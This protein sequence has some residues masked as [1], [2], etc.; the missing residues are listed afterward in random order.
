MKTPESLLLAVAAISGRRAERRLG[1][2][3]VSAVDGWEAVIP[4]VEQFGNL[5]GV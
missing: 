2:P 3:S 4:W 1:Q 5:D